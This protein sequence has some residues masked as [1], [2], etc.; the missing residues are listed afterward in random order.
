MI[1]E[2]IQK[3]SFTSEQEK[4][5]HLKEHSVNGMFL[6][7]GIQQDQQLLPTSLE[8]FI[9]LMSYGIAIPFL[10]LVSHVFLQSMMRIV[11]ISN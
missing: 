8:Y 10:S 5:E 9:S 6:V 7:G 11:N 4:P 2:L 1:I 3:L